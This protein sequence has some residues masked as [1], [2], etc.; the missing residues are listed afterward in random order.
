VG[1]HLE[2]QQFPKRCGHLAGKAIVPKEDMGDRLRAAA[3]ARRDE[4]FLIIAR[5]DARAVEGYDGAVERAHYYLKC[6]ADAVFPEAMQTVGEF[7]AF[8][9]AVDAPLMA[10]MTEFGK[11]PLLPIEQL[12][13]MGYRM[14]IFPQSCF[15]A[16]SFSTAAMLADLNREGTQKG[17]LDRMQSRDELYYTLRYDPQAEVWPD[18]SSNHS[19]E[20]KP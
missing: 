16:A 8:A 11:S 17:W 14:A 12:K 4:Q 6:G 19:Q 10:N 18:R 2:D 1:L 9:K 5:T 20:Q 3:D 7:E 13:A 15:R